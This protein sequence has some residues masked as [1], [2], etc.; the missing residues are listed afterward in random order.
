M[1]NFGIFDS[2]LTGIYRCIITCGTRAIK[3]EH[4][5]L[6]EHGN[7][8]RVVFITCCL[9]HPCYSNSRNKSV[10]NNHPTLLVP[11][12]YLHSSDES[13]PAV[14]LCFV[15]S[16]GGKKYCIYYEIFIIDLKYQNL[17]NH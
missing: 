15:F 9:Q 2:L 6:L 12:S 7:K 17:T 5:G 14:R 8:E 1:N 3:Y 4:V 10:Y 13:C 11:Y 16:F